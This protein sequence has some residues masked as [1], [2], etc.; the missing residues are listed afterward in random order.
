MS[1]Q[2]GLWNF[3]HSRIQ[4]GQ[5]ANIKSTLAPYAPEGLTEYAGSEIHLLHLPFR[6]TRESEQEIQPLRTR[7]GQMLLWDGRLDNRQDLI[8]SVATELQSCTDAEI[9]AAAIEQWGIE[10]LGRLVGDWALSVWNP[11]EQT[12]LLAKDFLGTRALYYA[13]EG[14]ACAWST[15]LDPLVLPKNHLVCLQEEYVAGWLT[16]FPGTHVTPFVGIQSVPPGSYVLFRPRATTVRQYWNFDANK[17]IVY[18][19]DREYEEHFR[20][21]FGES[22][23]R[24][25]RARSPVLSELSGGMD[26]TSIVCMADALAPQGITE[27]P[28]L[29]TISYYDDS[30]PNWNESPFFEKVERQRGRTGTHVALKFRDHW[31]PVFD[32]NIFAGTPGSGSNVSENADYAACLESGHY[33]V[34]LQG[35]GGDEF[36]GGVP[37]PVPELGDLLRSGRLSKFLRQSMVW[38]VSTRTPAVHL[39]L[40]TLRQFLPT[41]VSRDGSTRPPWLDPRFVKRNS[42]A[43]HAYARRFHVTGASPSFQANLAALDSV[44]RQVASMGL[45]SRVRI[46][47]RYPCLDRD[48]LEFLFAIPR[49][50][51]VRPNQRRSLMR[52]S[53]VGIVPAD[54]LNRRRKAFIARAPVVSLQAELPQ[55]L[56]GAPNMI[57]SR[58]GIVNATAFCDC[59]KKAALGAELPVVHVLR[60]LLIDAWLTHLS[61]W[62]RL[63]SA[64][65]VPGHIELAL[66]GGHTGPPQHF[67]S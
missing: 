8:S 1:V 61:G 48:L 19:D 23:R 13:V 21:V 28:R 7:S 67:F 62:P 18:R 5:I 41:L 43:L 31:R 55:L 57:S 22:V 6:V 40:S 32:P 64:P 44:R 27:A 10:G 2:F 58:M 59:L 11:Q 49:E 36:L 42:N 30:E 46:E 53:L 47:R 17:K 52:R 4:P 45:S 37:T 34:L 12:V 3:D 63:P 51:I 56:D 38:A 39:L 24:R 26:S 16:H 29:D 20:S 54:I 33:R 60:T 50:Q 15:L 25:L 35:I 9:A 66:S 14:R 65:H